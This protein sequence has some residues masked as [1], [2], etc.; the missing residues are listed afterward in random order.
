MRE[1][2]G[3]RHAVQGEGTR[4]IAREREPR[5][6]AVFKNDAPA[7][8]TREIVYSKFPKPHAP[9]P[10]HPYPSHTDSL[11][12][13]ARGEPLDMP[14][15]AP[16]DRPP[17]FPPPD[18]DDWRQ[19]G[20]ARSPHRTLSVWGESGPA[21]THPPPGS[22]L[23]ALAARSPLAPSLPDSH[24]ALLARQPSGV[25]Q[26]QSVSR[27]AHARF[28]LC[29]LPR[30]ALGG[31]C[32]DA[33]GAAWRFPQGVLRAARAGAARVR[34][35]RRGVCGAPGCGCVSELCIVSVG[36]C[37]V[38]ASAA[39][40]YHPGG[41]DHRRGRARARHQA[42]HRG[43]RCGRQD[44]HRSGHRRCHP[45]RGVQSGRCRRHPGEYPAVPVAPGGL[46]GVRVQIRR[47][48]QRDVSRVVA[49]HRRHIRGCR[50]VGGAA[51]RAG[52]HR[53][54]A[55][56]CGDAGR[57]GAQAAG[58]VRACGRQIGGGPGGRI[59]G[60]QESAAARSGRAGAHQFRDAAGVGRRR[61]SQVAATA[62]ARTRTAGATDGLSRRGADG[63]AAQGHQ[64][65]VHR[66]RR[67]RRG[68]HICR[69]AHEHTD[70]R[71]VR[72]R[73]R[74]LVVVVQAAAAAVG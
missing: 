21:S 49:R 4:R 3:R 43:G 53:R 56:G 40:R 37:I 26:L 36:I 10:D 20:R 23:S 62:G 67:P 31:V 28:R 1:S 65:G 38:Y 63:S 69:H 5:P 44:H 74:D 39:D 60:G 61:L 12:W 72:Y 42:A 2:P 51:G 54:V 30:H 45:S 58:G 8:G 29:L 70:R 48:L 24:G 57:A 41:G 55:G 22:R 68:S 13:H 14:T 18:A 59:G 7:A 25:F 33:R 35:H 6:R 16:A 17:Q 34:Q 73:R 50:E 71:A 9:P 27:A 19:L 64:H 15:P 66:V 47:P 32:G 11:L 46:G 52:R